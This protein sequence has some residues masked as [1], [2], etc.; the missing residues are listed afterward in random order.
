MKGAVPRTVQ[1]AKR[2]APACNRQPGGALCTKFLQIPVDDRLD[3]AQFTVPRERSHGTDELAACSRRGGIRSRSGD[4]HERIAAAHAS[5]RGSGC[6]RSQWGFCSVPQKYDLRFPSAYRPWI[7]STRPTDFVETRSFWCRLHHF[8]LALQSH[9]RRGASGNCHGIAPGIES[10]GLTP[11]V[12]VQPPAV[13]LSKIY[14]QFCQTQV[15]AIEHSA[16]KHFS[17]HALK[18]R[19]SRQQ[20]FRL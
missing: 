9:D 13:A 2:Q 10:A 1:N 19:W 7:R 20:F 14:F 18:V 4:D 12:S 8:E 16:R 5:R 3:R 6:D 17:L 11:G 15:P